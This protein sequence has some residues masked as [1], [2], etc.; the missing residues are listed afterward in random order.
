MSEK[1]SALDAA[2]FVGDASKAQLESGVA[3]KL[4]A[5][6]G[7]ISVLPVGT[8]EANGMLWRALA[9]QAG[10]TPTEFMQ[11]VVWL[12]VA[13]SKEMSTRCLADL[14]MALF[15][16]LTGFPSAAA[17]PAPMAPAP[18]PAASFGGAFGAFGGAPPPAILGGLGSLLAPTPAAVT[19]TVSTSA[20]LAEDIAS[21]DGMTEG[22]IANLTFL[23]LTARLSNSPDVKYGGDM[24]SI[25]AYRHMASGTVSATSTL[26]PDLVAASSTATKEQI[27]A[28]MTDAM[29]SAKSIGWAAGAQRI[30][31]KW[32]KLSRTFGSVLLIRLYLAE[33]LRRYRGR[34][35]P[36]LLD[37]DIVILV[38]GAVVG[39]DDRSASEV[40]ALSGLVSKLTAKVTELA[41]TVSELK[42]SAAEQKNELK[43]L[44]DSAKK[45]NT[46]CTWCK[47]WGHT[48]SECDQKAQGKP[49][50]E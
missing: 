11:L 40:S 26:L 32:H 7:V 5:A 36:V 12:E 34:G 24:T 27:H 50:S 35:L 37:T 18:A 30:S 46:R 31:D 1:M 4:I 9:M 41:A 47:G 10:L 44:K 49:K 28:H 20:K 48:E 14:P 15:T 39:A 13:Y 6:H 45:K 8:A 3:T 22:E 29:E 43:Q 16:S 42:V 19:S 38:L 23:F 33:Y 21:H 17:P 2:L 25:K